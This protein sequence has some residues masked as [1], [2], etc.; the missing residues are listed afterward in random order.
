MYISRNTVKK[1]KKSYQENYLKNV[2]ISLS[3][4]K[5]T[6]NIKDS[7]IENILETHYESKDEKSPRH[8]ESGQTKDFCQP[9]NSINSFLFLLVVSYVGTRLK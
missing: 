1:E 8:I 3:N 9:L 6:K 7:L 5:Y 4:G 2:S